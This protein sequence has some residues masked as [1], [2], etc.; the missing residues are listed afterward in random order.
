[1]DVLAS[2]ARGPIPYWPV[3]WPAG[4][5]LARHL[6]ALDLGEQRVLEVGCGVG[7]AGLGAALAGAETLV[8]DNQP[9]ALRLACMNAR[10][11]GLNLSA[12]AADWRQWPFRRGCDFDLV[13]GSDVT[14][15]PA[16]FD[17][18]LQVLDDSL[19]L[20]GTV[21]LSDPGRLMTT[22]FHQRAIAAGWTWSTETLPR[23]G[24]QSVFLHRMTRRPKTKTTK[25]CEN[26]CGNNGPETRGRER[27]RTECQ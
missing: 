11:A 27:N 24:T 20:E 9:P 16:A 25:E 1:M 15:E 17:A 10:R 4:L 5:G 19:R 26:S 8:T 7:I 22:A 6:S 3:A 21:L 18:L 14:Y 23:E 2:A 13:I 12:A